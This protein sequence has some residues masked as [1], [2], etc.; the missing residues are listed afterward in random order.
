MK[1]SSKIPFFLHPT[2][3]RRL[4][5]K[6]IPLQVMVNSKMQ[7]LFMGIKI[8]Y[9]FLSFYISCTYDRREPRRLERHEGLQADRHSYAPFRSNRIE[10]LSPLKSLLRS[11]NPVFLE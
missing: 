6:D 2:G 3:A 11:K 9:E 4:S 10:F 7:D 5:H 8:I 1:F